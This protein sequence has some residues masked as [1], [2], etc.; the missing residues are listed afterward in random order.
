MWLEF[1]EQQ[2]AR[3]EPGEAAL[4]RVLHDGLVPGDR[5]AAQRGARRRVDALERRRERPIGDRAGHE[6]GR[7]AGADLDDPSRPA[8][9]DHRVGDAGVERREPVL[10]EARRRRRPAEPLERRRQRL[11]LG[12]HLVELREL[13]GE[14]R[15]ERRVGAG[16]HAIGIAVGDE[17][18]ARP[19]AEQRREAHPQPPSTAARCGCRHAFP[20]LQDPGRSPDP[21]PPRRGGG[22]RRRPVTRLL[23]PVDGA[24]GGRPPISPLLPGW[25]RRRP[26]TSFVPPPP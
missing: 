17:E 24:G 11:D 5:Q 13:S 6:A 14:Q 3:R 20:R 7:V 12:Q 19:A 10:L 23:S 15:R 18:A 2:V 1:D 25:G 8:A 9:R 4:R 22:R 21:N 16:R 26:S